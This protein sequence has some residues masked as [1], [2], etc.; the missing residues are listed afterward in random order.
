MDYNGQIKWLHAL[1]HNS[2]ANQNEQREKCVREKN[3]IREKEKEE[4]REK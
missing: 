1:V 3:R 2:V 4:E